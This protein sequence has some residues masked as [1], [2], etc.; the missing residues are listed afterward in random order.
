[1]RELGCG[2]PVY[3]H[4]TNIGITNNDKRAGGGC[5][6]HLLY[7]QEWLHEKWKI[8]QSFRQLMKPVTFAFLLVVLV[9]LL[10]IC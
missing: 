10:S 1:M 5:W 2:F 3:Q 4:S 9:P 6:L 8:A 7:Y